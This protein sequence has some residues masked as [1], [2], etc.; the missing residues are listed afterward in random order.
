MV[1][2]YFCHVLRFQILMWYP[3][4]TCS[5]YKDALFKEPMSTYDRYIPPINTLISWPEIKT[6]PPRR[7]QVSPSA[8]VAL[9]LHEKVQSNLPLY[10]R[11]NIP[12]HL[13][14]LKLQLLHTES[15]SSWMTR[16]TKN[17]HQTSLPKY[18][19]LKNL[20]PSLMDGLTTIINSNRT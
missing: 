7:Q 9:P 15:I 12:T 1:Y 19:H 4:R 20:L 16:T 11:D 6:R 2:W 18:L 14:T 8:T 5:V 10:Q 17:N 13:W 3:S